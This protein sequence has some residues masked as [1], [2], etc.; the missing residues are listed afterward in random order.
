VNEKKKA[1][2]KEVKQAKIKKIETNSNTIS[3]SANTKNKETTKK[4]FYDDL[5][6]KTIFVQQEDFE[7]LML[8]VEQERFC[9]KLGTI[10]NSISL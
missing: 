2:F 4:I 6:D 5:L 7:K 10:S 3:T 1:L 9:S 8:L